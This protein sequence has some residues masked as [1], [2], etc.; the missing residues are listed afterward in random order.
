LEFNAYQTYI[1]ATL[2]SRQ[3]QFGAPLDV[4]RSALLENSFSTNKYI[5]LA[6]DRLNLKWSQQR[7]DLTLGRQT[8]NLASTFFFTPNDFFAPFSAQAFYRV[9]KPGVDGVRAE[10]RLSNLSFLEVL[11]VMGYANDVQST[12]G[13]ADYPDSELASYL[14]RGFVNFADSGFGMFTGVIRDNPV[15]GASVQ[16][17]LWRW[18]GVRMEGHV[19]DSKLGGQQTEIAVGIEHHWENST[20][21]RLEYFFHGS[22]ANDTEDYM[23]VNSGG[24]STYLAR[25]YA[26][27][28]LSYEINPLLQGQSV[29]ITNFT[30]QSNL[31][32]LN[33]NYSLSDETELSLNVAIPI[34]TEPVGSL[35]NSEF[36]LLPLAINLELRSY[37]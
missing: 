25:Q 28:G 16:S 6:V 8:I 26:A 1:P 14:F 23:Q 24:N 21:L 9:F 7:L 22:G 11:A 12:N 32:S 36:G 30:D 35:I 19:M 37:F 4:E 34:G 31:L 29:L 5:H 33:A 2:I 17:E 27:V 13:W 10:Y 3:G 18:L 15:V 20:D